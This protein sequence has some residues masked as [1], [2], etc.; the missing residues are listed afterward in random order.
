MIQRTLSQ[1]LSSL[2]GQFPIVTITGPRQSG[3]T[4]LTRM[5]FTN[6]EYVSLEEPHEREF[7]NLE[8]IKD[9]YEKMVISMDRFFPA[10]RNGILHRYIIDFLLE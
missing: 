8:K 7:G 10:E 3:K 1:K 2:A 6:H 9:N 5:L 4:T